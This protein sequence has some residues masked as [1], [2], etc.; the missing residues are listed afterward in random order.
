MVPLAVLLLVLVLEL[1]EVVF[2]VGAGD[3]LVGAGALLLVGAADV[4]LA[5]DAS[6]VSVTVLR[7]RVKS[8][9]DVRIRGGAKLTKF[10]CNSN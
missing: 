1:W 4:S 10:Y 3:A 8:G 6:M 2:S 9:E 7:I 5:S